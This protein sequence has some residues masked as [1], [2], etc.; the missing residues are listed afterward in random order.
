MD[1]LAPVSEKRSRYVPYIWKTQHREGILRELEWDNSEN[2]RS[3]KEIL[4]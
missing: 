2:T 1:K 4:N 3:E